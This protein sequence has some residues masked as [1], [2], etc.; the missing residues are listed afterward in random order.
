M[1][2]ISKIKTVKLLTNK[3]VLHENTKNC[4]ICKERFEDKYVKDK[5]YSK[6]RDHC[7][8]TGE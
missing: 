5:K 1:K 8:Y 6:A 2:I 3:Q 4:Y 7:H